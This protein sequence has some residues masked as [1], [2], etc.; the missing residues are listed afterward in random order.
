MN[1]LT[2]QVF[3]HWRIS[4]QERRKKLEQIQK[5]QTLQVKKSFKKLATAA[6]R[7]KQIPLKKHTFRL[8]QIHVKALNYFKKT[9][10]KKVF[11]RLK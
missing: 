10:L 9:T 6:F 7:S 4:L 5:A 8:W 11:S 3:N 2:M 1:Q